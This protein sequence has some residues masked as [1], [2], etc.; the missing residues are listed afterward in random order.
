M[1]DVEAAAGAGLLVGIFAGGASSRMGTPKGLLRAP[2]SDEALLERLWRVSAEALPGAERAVVGR[3]D[4]YAGFGFET[5][6]DAAECS[7]PLAG[8]VALLRA[9]RG[10]GAR[11]VITLACDFPY[12]GAPLLKRLATE[13]PESPIVCPHL[14]DRYQPLFARYAVELLDPFELALTGRRLSLQP[15]V[16]G[17][18]RLRL[19]PEEERELRDWDHPSDIEP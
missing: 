14:D 13:H 2:G 12:L 18:E 5:L 3:L 10:A 4:A 15:L 11:A 17:A 16:R 9:G 7:G 6:E 8:L 19:T 1:T